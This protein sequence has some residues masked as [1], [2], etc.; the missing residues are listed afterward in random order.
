MQVQPYEREGIPGLPDEGKF[1]PRYTEEPNS[2]R[3]KLDQQLVGSLAYIATF[4]RPDVARA[5]S[6]LA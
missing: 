6:V 2:E 4:T 5:H 1:L 3:T